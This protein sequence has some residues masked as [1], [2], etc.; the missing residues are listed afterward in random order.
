MKMYSDGILTLKPKDVSV[1]NNH[2]E[3]PSDKED[4]EGFQVTFYE[5]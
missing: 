1:K 5:K 4:I 3:I 2:D